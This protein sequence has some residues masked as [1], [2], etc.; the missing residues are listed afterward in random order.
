M[1]K[2]KLQCEQL[3]IIIQ[4]IQHYNTKKLRKSFKQIDK[5]I[6]YN[7]YTLIILLPMAP[8]VTS[9]CPQ[10]GTVRHVNCQFHKKMWNKVIQLVSTFDI[11]TH[12]NIDSLENWG[13]W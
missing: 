10:Q 2:S 9:I 11:S 6:T 8:I 12:V 13:I 3:G 5:Q 4:I 7:N 1:D